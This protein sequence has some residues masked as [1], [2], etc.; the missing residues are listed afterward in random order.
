MPQLH[1][2]KFYLRGKRSN[3]DQVLN[4]SLNIAVGVGN[5]EAISGSVTCCN[6]ISLLKIMKCYFFWILY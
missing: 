6:S 2:T 1:S 3:F 5:V 4:K